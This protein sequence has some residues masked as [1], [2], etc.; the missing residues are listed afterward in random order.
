[1]S[2]QCRK[3]TNRVQEKRH[4]ARPHARP[5]V[6]YS[7]H[8]RGQEVLQ[9]YAYRYKHVQRMCMCVGSSVL[10]GGT[11]LKGCSTP[12]KQNLYKTAITYVQP[13]TT[14]MRSSKAVVGQSM[15]TIQGLVKPE[16]NRER[17]A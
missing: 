17:E 16:D 2:E 11:H 7:H 15:H 5:H 4:Q 3:L 9:A 8:S 14:C 6:M 1:M 10:S 13:Y 12:Q